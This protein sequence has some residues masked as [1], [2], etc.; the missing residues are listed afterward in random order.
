[1][2]D[3][4]VIRSHIEE[5]VEQLGDSKKARDVE[6]LAFHLITMPIIEG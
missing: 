3:D 5:I 6:T 1:L 2:Q 4:P